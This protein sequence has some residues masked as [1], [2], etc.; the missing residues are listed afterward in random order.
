MIASLRE[1]KTRL[2]ELVA[3]AN[4]GEE[5]LLGREAEVWRY[6]Q[7]ILWERQGDTGR[8]NSMMVAL[9]AERSYYGFLAA[10]HLGKAYAFNRRQLVLEPADADK[11]RQLPPLRRIGE[12]NYHEQY[13]LAH[14]EWYKVLQDSPDA[15]QTQQLAQLANQQ[16]WYRMGIDAA[17]AAKA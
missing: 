10:G 13:N 9:A 3:L 17:S 12:L 2:S 6:W 4:A 15:G 8:A 14:S 7:A 16:G 11:L 1:S 5:V